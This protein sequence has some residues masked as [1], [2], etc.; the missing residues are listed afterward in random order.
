M[1]TADVCALLKTWD[2]AFKAGGEAEL[3]ANLSQAIREARCTHAQKIEQRFC[4]TGDTPQM[5][6]SKLSITAQTLSVGWTLLNGLNHSYARFED[7]NNRAAGKTPPHTDEQALKLIT[8]PGSL[9]TAGSVTHCS[10]MTHNCCQTQLKLSNRFAEN[11]FVLGLISQRDKTPQ[12]LHPQSNSTVLV[13]HSLC[14]TSSP[15]RDCAD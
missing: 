13:S 11:T 12:E 8:A 1:F 9:R 4:G 10:L 7:P 2:N 15:T 6:Q 14:T 3:R 5:W